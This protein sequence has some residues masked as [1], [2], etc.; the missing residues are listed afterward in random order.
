MLCVINIQIYINICLGELPEEHETLKSKCSCWPSA[1][2][3]EFEITLLANKK[4]AGYGKEIYLIILLYMNQVSTKLDNVKP[5]S[6]N[7][8][9]THVL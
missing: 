9:G 3:N 7:N 1:I 6:K 2:A 5:N 4:G 8:L